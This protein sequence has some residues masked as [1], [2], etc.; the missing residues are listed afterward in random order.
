MTVEELIHTGMVYGIPFPAIYDWTW[1]EIV[2]HI[3][4]KNETRKQELREEAT[5]NFRTVALLARMLVGQSGQ[6][7]SVMDEYDFLWSDE[8]RAEARRAEIES[9]FRVANTQGGD[10]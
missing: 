5:M 7:F 6:K 10:S 2:E 9:R 8:E 4:C 3:E 1:G